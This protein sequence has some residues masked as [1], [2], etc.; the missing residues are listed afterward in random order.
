MKELIRSVC[1]VF[2]CIFSVFSQESNSGTRAFEF[3]KINDNARTMA[4]GG[5]AVAMPNDAYGVESNPA[6]CGYI[7]QTQAVA[8]YL[9]YNADAWGGPVAYVMPYKNYGVIGGSISY[10][11]HG[12]LSESEALDENGDLLG[13]TWHVFSLVGGLSWAKQ[14]IPNFSTGVTIKGIHHAIEGS[15][16]YTTSSETYSATGI[17]MD[18]GAQYRFSTKTQV[19]IGGTVRNLGFLVSNYSDE[20]DNLSLPLSITAGVSV[21]PAEIPALRIAVDLEKANDDYLNYKGGAEYELVKGFFVRAGYSFSENDLEDA[22]KSFSGSSSDTYVKSNANG[23][24]VGLG[25]VTTFNGVNAHVDAAYLSSLDP[26]IALT[27]MFSY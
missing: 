17:A 20:Q 9:K 26:C 14:F 15:A 24:S 4:M 5:A 25:F 2:L 1:I 16:G 12:S 6:A 21:V 23:L 13:S 22:L 7:T 10:L 3:L 8:G 27:F 18:I 19:I 11:S